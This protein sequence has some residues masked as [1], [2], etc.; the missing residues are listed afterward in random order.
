MKAVRD[1]SNRQHQ[2]QHQQQLQHYS[3]TLVVV[4]VVVVVVVGG[5]LGPLF[6]PCRC[7]ILGNMYALSVRLLKGGLVK[8][9]LGKVWWGCAFKRL[10]RNNS[11]GIEQ[12][13]VRWSEQSVTSISIQ[14]SS[15]A[16]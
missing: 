4:V 10:I 11:T 5:L 12:E 16:S 3:G 8:K 13:V 7:T 9:G 15:S 6:A 2:Q 1:I 14:P